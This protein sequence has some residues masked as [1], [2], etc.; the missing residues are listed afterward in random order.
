M[1]AFLFPVLPQLVFHLQ[2][3]C[4]KIRLLPDCPGACVGT[5]KQ[6]RS[7]VMQHCITQYTVA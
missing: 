4:G 7:P 5:R 3:P 1:A 2:S 6:S